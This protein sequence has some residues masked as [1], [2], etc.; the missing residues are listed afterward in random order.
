VW[1][2][3]FLSWFVF[4]FVAPKTF[5]KLLGMGRDGPFPML[6]AGVYNGPFWLLM[7][8]AAVADWLSGGRG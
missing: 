7:A 2:G 8:I 1:L 4:S 6:A 3:W 5:R